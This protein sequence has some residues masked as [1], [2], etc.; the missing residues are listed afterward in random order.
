LP[1][2]RR[3]VINV[4]VTQADGAGTTGGQAEDSG[5]ASLAIVR[6][7]HGIPVDPNQLRHDFGKLR[8]RFAA[9]D[10]VIA[11]RRLGL[12]ARTLTSDWTRLT[13]TAL[14]ALIQ[15][16]DGSFLARWRAYSAWLETGK[17]G[18]VSAAAV[19]TADF[20]PGAAPPLPESSIALQRSLLDQSIAQQRSKIASID[21]TLLRRRAEAESTRQILEKLKQT[22]PLVSQRAES[23]KKLLRTESCCEEFLRRGA[24][25]QGPHHR[26]RRHARGAGRER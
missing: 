12:K 18:G 5:L 10:L 23:L 22:L 3:S 4:P 6:R 16:E 24:A 1:G 7:F 13:Q 15:Q 8:E 26:R 25:T 17:A 20:G 2:L 14:P 11:A 19:A 21:Q 9:S